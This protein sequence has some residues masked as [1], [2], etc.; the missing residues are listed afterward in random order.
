MLE[1][2]MRNAGSV[3]SRERILLHVWGPDSEVESGNIDNYIHLVRR[4]LKLVGSHTVLQTR[5]G[6]GYC[7]EVPVC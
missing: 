1:L 7:L 6:A 2:L 5:R 3:V 4:R